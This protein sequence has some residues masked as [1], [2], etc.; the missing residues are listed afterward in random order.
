MRRFL[1]PGWIAALSALL[2]GV[3]VL[4]IGIGQLIES[5]VNARDRALDDCRSL[6]ASAVTDT[7]TDYL[8]A[9]GD[10]IEA[11]ATSGDRDAALRSMVDAGN[12]LSDARDSRVAFEANPTG[13]C[14]R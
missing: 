10:L 4:T 11:L 7:Q 8:L 14:D 13:D 6:V 12:A 3:G 2:A 1:T 9:Q 5:N